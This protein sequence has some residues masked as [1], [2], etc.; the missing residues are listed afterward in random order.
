MIKTPYFEA[1]SHIA[2]PAMSPLGTRDRALWHIFA[3]ATIGFGIWYLHWRWTA[4]LNPD[5]L[6]FSVLIAV[7]ETLA[8]LGTLLFFFDI[9]DEADTPPLAPP[10]NRSTAGL[11]GAGPIDVDV[12]ITSYDEDVAIVEPS[13]SAAQTLR[14]PPGVRARVFLLDDGNRPEM[15]RLCQ[16]TGVDYLY[17]NDNRG[18]KAGNLANALF[19][20]GGDFILICD[21]DTRLFPS[22]LENTLGYFRDPMVSWVQTPHWF[23]DLTPGRSWED[24]LAQR[25]GSWAGPFA[26]LVQKITGRA[27]CGQDIFLSDPQFFFDVIQRRRNRNAA[28]FCCGAGSIHRREAV[29]DSALIEQGAQLKRL[30]KAAPAGAGQKLLPRLDLQPFRF[31]VSEDIFTSIQH[32][33]K[34]WKSVYHP[35]V[36]ARML[37]PW[38]VSAWAVQKLKY[39][40]GTFDIML[41]ANPLFQRGMPWRS[42]LHYMATFW[43]YLSILWL[44]VLILAPAF[45]LVT[46]QAP[47]ASFSPEFFAHFL[48]VLISNE[49]AMNFACKGNNLAAGR[50]LSIGTLFIQWRAFLQVLRGQK[51]HFPPTPKI[52]VI[53][54]SLRHAVPNL[55]LL[56]VLWGGVAYG[57]IRYLEDTP[58][59]S[60]AFF[61]MNVFW[62]TWVSLALCRAV[63]CAL[64]PP[65]LPPGNQHQTEHQRGHH[66]IAS[67]I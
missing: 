48:P 57:G 44:P 30:T 35:N 11:D 24:W 7:C 14:V 16:R 46:G 28:S 26:P 63:I 32:Q 33:K 6:T 53:S 21:A 1:F 31:H 15:R 2:P 8:F 4:S 60:A 61:W 13:L 67:K 38:S 55:V 10:S 47:L 40:G 29:F 36:E 43:S 37:S 19:Q 41:N 5:A 42:K 23:Y 9:W 3:G 59:Y 65:Y 64:S 58:A 62:I 66:G 49:L 51:P 27:R 52:P 34:G 20:T 50:V 39:A 18:F 25:F 54:T 17:R 22:F 12:F 45:S 56:A